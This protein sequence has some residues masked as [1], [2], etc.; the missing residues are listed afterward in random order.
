MKV[1]KLIYLL[2]SSLGL[3]LLSGAFLPVAYAQEEIGGAVQ[4]NG[5][6]GFY[7]GDAPIVDSSTTN[8]STAASSYPTTSG[9]TE[10]AAA[11]P[12]GKYPSTGELVKKSLSFSGAA[13]I[14]IA[15]FLFL[16]KRKKKEA[17]E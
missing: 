16:M 2:F 8:S 1:K 9:S 3:L 12:A 15:L 17:E 6:I 7:E 11:K 5:E 13:L 10:P 4:T 14:L